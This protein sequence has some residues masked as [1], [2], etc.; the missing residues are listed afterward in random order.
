MAVCFFEDVLASVLLNIMS[1]EL[2]MWSR[3]LINLC[4]IMHDSLCMVI[5]CL[6]LMECLNLLT[7]LCV[8]LG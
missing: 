2:S 1:L 8:L 6:S 3:L 7:L 4:L 5:S